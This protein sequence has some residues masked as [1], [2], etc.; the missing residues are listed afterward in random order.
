MT[1]KR[2][3]IQFIPESQMRVSGLGDW[4]EDGDTLHIRALDGGLDGG[5]HGPFLVALHEMIESY[6]CIANGITTEQVDAF[7]AQFEAE[8]HPSDLE[9][10]DDMRAPYRIEHRRACLAEFMVASFLGLFNYG[11]MR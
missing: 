6:L 7:D 1:I 9:P 10:G 5:E 8:D 11:V 3:D 2:I 4:Y